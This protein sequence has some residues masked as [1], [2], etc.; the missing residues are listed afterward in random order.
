ML[1]GE[2]L[3]WAAAGNGREGDNNNSIF[4]AYFGSPLS[5]KMLEIIFEITFEV[6]FKIIFK[7]I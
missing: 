1:Q 6:M 2:I 4:L 7:V 3:E 5:E